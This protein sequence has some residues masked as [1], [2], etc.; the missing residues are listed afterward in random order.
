MKN[1]IK[2]YSILFETPEYYKSQGKGTGRLNKEYAR[3]LFDLYSEN[4]DKLF[5]YE[6]GS[7]TK[8]AAE[9]SSE[10]ENRGLLSPASDVEFRRDILLYVDIGNQKILIGPT[11]LTPLQDPRVTLQLTSLL[12]VFPEFSNYQVE[13]DT[14][15]SETNQWKKIKVGTLKNLIAKKKTI[16][17]KF[18]TYNKNE[19]SFEEYE[20]EVLQ[21]VTEIDWYH[22]TARK[23]WNSI[24]RVGL[25]P[26]KEFQQAQ[27]HGWTTLNF[28]LQNAVY[29]T[30]S[31]SH[32]E[33][34]A[35]AIAEKFGEPAIV[36]KV[37]GSALKDTSHIAVDEDALRNDFDGNVS[38]GMSL[39]GMPNYFTSI[40]HR[41]RSIGYTTTIQPQFIS[42]V[43]LIEPETEENEENQS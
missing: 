11:S 19:D 17:G 14:V 43:E 35:Q 25:V 38:G 12:E 28:D 10:K 42:F 36:L 4:G 3:K 41:V 30:Y 32:A 5:R 2:L 37:K 22:A 16:S 9:K 31:K 6:F 29:L 26:S 8:T 40:Q 24:K 1:Y 7:L 27:Q 23:N 20:F 15:D 18:P 34:I 13:L 21:D 33:D 39:S